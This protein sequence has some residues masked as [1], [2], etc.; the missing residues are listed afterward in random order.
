MEFEIIETPVSFSL[1]GLSSAVENNNYAATGLSLMDRMWRIVK[2][3]ETRTTGINH[4]V[5]LS[6]NRMFTGVELL[7]ASTA[8]EKL[9]CLKFQLGRHLKHTHIGP[10]SLLPSKWAAL[11]TE[12]TRRGESIGAC[13]LE[14]YGHH[15]DDP[16]RAE[17]TILIGLE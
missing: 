9:E 8:P 3:S 17:T 13:S 5:Y 15:C 6:G 16:S 10:Y 14:V 11:K 1:A 7:V 2:E 4:W 12:L